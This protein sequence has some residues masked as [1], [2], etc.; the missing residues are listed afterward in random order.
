MKKL[1]YLLVLLLLLAFTACSE[2]DNPSEVKI[3]GY[4]LDQFINPDTVRIYIDPQAEADLGCSSLLLMKSSVQL[5]D[6]VLVKV[7]MQVMTCHR[8][9][10]RRILY[11][12]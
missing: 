2:K 11:S 5:M 10:F 7:L 8:K 6:S 1:I 12:Q 4:K 3:L 9:L